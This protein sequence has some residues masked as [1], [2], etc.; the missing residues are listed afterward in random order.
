VSKTALT[1]LVRR[2][3]NKKTGYGLSVPV[4]F[5]F[6][7]LLLT[8][9]GGDSS[10]ASTSAT[11]AITGGPGTTASS[12]IKGTAQPAS[13]AVATT[14]G[15][16]NNATDSYV[17]EAPPTPTAVTGLREEDQV[18]NLTGDNIESFDPALLAAA[19]SSFILRQIYSG[20]VTL[21]KDLKVVPDLAAK[22][23]EISEQG[24][25]YT[26]TLRPGAK[27]QSGREVTADDLK[28]SM[29]RA[30]D[31]KLAAPDSASSLPAASYMSD[32]VGVKDKLEGRAT[33]ISGVTVK[34][35]ATLQIKIDS[36]RP[37]FLAK[38]TY[39]VFY[40]VNPD[41][42]AKGFDQP[43]GTGPFKLAE[44]QR[45]QYIRLVRNE[46][47]YGRKAY[48]AKI[49]IALGA[50]ASNGLTQYEQNKFDLMGIDSSNV[51]RAQ[52]KNS[53]LSKE[54]VVKPELSLTYLGFNTRAR[55]FD[56]PKIRQAFSIVIDRAKIARVMYEGKVQAATTILPPGI[57]GYSG[58]AGLNVYDINRARAL[59]AQSSYRTAG[60]LPKIVLYSTG[61]SL[62]R[63]LQ[64][65]YKQAFDID[66]EVRQSDYKDFQSGL[67]ARQFQMYIFGWSADYPDPENFLRTLLG[68]GSPFNDTGYNN[69]QFDDL[70]KQGDQ[71]TDPQ[72]RLQFY[73]QAEQIALNDAPIF[74]LTNGVN[75]LL[76]KP[77]VKGLDL[78]AVGVWSL[79]DVY[80]KK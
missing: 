66:L 65:V 16:A 71:Q 10:P 78:T 61:S 27:F 5:V 11:K 22:M 2:S 19:D 57:P 76:V 4:L 62:A 50:S 54:L 49:N 29:E 79:K 47:Y 7:A 37:Y 80:I 9:C 75:Y 24:T 73:A 69:S 48:L 33:Q 45:D 56:D 6:L 70:M 31:P 59:I 30:T 18:L 63:V 8:A 77:Y 38:M 28:F 25:L 64:E 3:I 43:D 32:I 17:P 67:T 34:D 52:D 44:Y 20:L 40:V 13:G 36:P 42:V 12:T 41:A 51:D 55:P 74:P 23:P 39:N 14:T 60:N 15:G 21:D 1:R 53:P 46:N 58:N 72:K 26:F 35:K 68:T